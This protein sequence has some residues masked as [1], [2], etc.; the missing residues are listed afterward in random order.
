MLAAS[1]AASSAVA[2]PYPPAAGI[3]GSTAISKDDPAIKG[4]ATGYD[5][6]TFQRG[7]ISAANESLGRVTFGEPEDALGPADVKIAFMETFSVVSL[8]DGG[9]ITLT[10]E[11]PITNGPGFD[12]AV[13][14]NSFS[15]VFLE[16]AFVEVSSDGEYFLRFPAF[17]LTPTANLVENPKVDDFS[18]LDP[19]NLHNLAGKYRGEQG[20]PFDL[21]ELPP[22]PRVDTMRITH[23]RIIDV[24]GSINPAW[25]S[26]DSE[27]RIIKDPFPTRFDSGGFDLDAVGVMNQVPEP[28]AGLSLGVAA[29]LLGLRR[30]R[31]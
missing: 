13:F 7:F 11:P 30:R 1:M 18:L 24:V 12:F 21:S 15:D 14:E 26:F 20:T 27:G 16:L 28:A 8:G 5:A 31:S 6:K 9:S 3:S 2:G 23:V 25:G 17:S 22:D 19:T 4:W 10:F 29:A